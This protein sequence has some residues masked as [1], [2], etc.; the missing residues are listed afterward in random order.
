MGKKRCGFYSYLSTG[1]VG[2]IDPVVKVDGSCFPEDLVYEIRDRNTR[3][4]LN[5]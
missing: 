3:C 2:P 5:L 4:I 1:S